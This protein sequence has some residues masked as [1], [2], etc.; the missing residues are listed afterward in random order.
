M[1]YFI[2]KTTDG[3]YWCINSIVRCKNQSGV[4]IT[5]FVCSGI[6]TIIETSRV[7]SITPSTPTP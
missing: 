1:D 5:T 3:Q 7:V 4:D 2:L 6:A